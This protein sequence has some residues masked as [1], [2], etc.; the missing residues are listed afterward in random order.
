[1]EI[2]TQISKDDLSVYVEGDWNKIL[3]FFGKEKVLIDSVHFSKY[4]I[5]ILMEVVEGEVTFDKVL[6]FCV[7]KKIAVSEFRR[8]CKMVGLSDL[9][10]LQMLSDYFEITCK[11]T[12]EFTI[13]FCNHLKNPS[14]KNWSKRALTPR[15]AEKLHQQLKAGKRYCSKGFADY[16]ECDS[17]ETFLL[18]RH[19][20]EKQK[21]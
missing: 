14:F 6:E 11:Y 12:G 21:A 5:A 7:G 2:A 15:Q 8:K 4:G 9:Q 10:G 3:Q 16:L 13:I 20:K 19:L 1:M 17:L 18:N